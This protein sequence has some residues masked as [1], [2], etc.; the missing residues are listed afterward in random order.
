MCDLRI[1]RYDGCTGPRS[2]ALSAFVDDVELA[3]RRT[4]RPYSVCL[5]DDE[6]NI[7]GGASGMTAWGFCELDNLGIDK[8]F[9]RQGWGRKLI[10]EVEKTARERGCNSIQ[11]N[12]MNFQ[13][14]DFYRHVGFV[15]LAQQTDATG[16]YTRYFLSKEVT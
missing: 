12:T 13:A 16:Q 4:D 5:Y 15:V 6:G 8:R 2:R 7:V 11:T 3:G 1:E 10:E 9:R 14:I